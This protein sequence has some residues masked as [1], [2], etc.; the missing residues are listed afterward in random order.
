MVLCQLLIFL[1]LQTCGPEQCLRYTNCTTCLYRIVN[2]QVQETGEESCQT[3]CDAVN[4]TVDTDAITGPDDPRLEGTFT[5]VADLVDGQ[6]SGI[7]FYVNPSDDGTAVILVSSSPTRECG[8]FTT[9]A[10]PP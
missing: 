5:C 2:G 9:K 3:I 1:C 10:A 8:S 7:T 6:C 4:A